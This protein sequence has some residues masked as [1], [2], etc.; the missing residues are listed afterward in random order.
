MKISKSNLPVNS[1][2]HAGHR[3]FDYVDGFRGYFED[4][5][6][7]VVI[8]DICREFFTSGPKWV[9]KLFW[10]R[11]K[12]VAVFGLKVPGTDNPNKLKAGNF[13]N[14]HDLDNGRIQQLDW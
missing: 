12:I 5:T 8:T 14:T 7:K 4:K 6:D 9:E 11:N 13:N 1:I 3:K 2:L 10:L